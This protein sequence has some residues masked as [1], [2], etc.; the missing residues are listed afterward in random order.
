LEDAPTLA[1][2]ILG[3]QQPAGDRSPEQRF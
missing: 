3:S 2:P 1:I